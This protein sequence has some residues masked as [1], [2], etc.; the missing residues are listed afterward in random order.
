MAE[1]EIDISAT[2]E[3]VFAILANPDRYAE[4]VLGTARVRGAD[5]TWP[6]PGSHLH[7]SV[8]AGP[9]TVDDSTEV[10]ECE[11]PERLVLLAHIGPVG[12]FR[13][14]LVL[15]AEGAATHVTMHEH[16][17]SGVSKLGGPATGAAIGVRNS[18]S[19]ER[20]KELA[21]A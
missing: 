18:L 8:G 5:S 7:H 2:R 9:V 3:Q 14:E 17:V 4:W 10:L 11:E 21:E 20:L 1:N 13:V 15:R 12:S 16:P 19:L 6:E